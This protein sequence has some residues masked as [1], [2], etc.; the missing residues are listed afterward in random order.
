VAELGRARLPLGEVVE[1]PPGAIVD[2]DRDAEEPVDLY[3]NGLAF[4]RGRLV[5][6]DGGEWAITI[7]DVL[8]AAAGALSAGGIEAITTNG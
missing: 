8:D 1:L 3:V 6:A 4:A 5:V 7:D 2:L